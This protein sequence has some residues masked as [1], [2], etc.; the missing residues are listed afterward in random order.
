M[1]LKKTSAPWILK[2]LLLHVP[3]KMCR[4]TSSF[5]RV[6]SWK[7]MACCVCSFWR[8]RWAHVFGNNLCNLKSIINKPPRRRLAVDFVLRVHISYLISCLTCT[9]RDAVLRLIRR[10]FLLSCPCHANVGS[11]PRPYGWCTQEIPP[12]MPRR[13]SLR[14][15]ASKEKFTYRFR[16]HKSGASPTACQNMFCIFQPMK[17]FRNFHRDSAYLNGYSW[18]FMLPVSRIRYLSKVPVSP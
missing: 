16:L 8:P 18:H 4:M 10:S 3:W 14:R 9:H 6:L 1:N 5:R 12:I 7:S 13:T 15:R 2:K 17:S 11:F